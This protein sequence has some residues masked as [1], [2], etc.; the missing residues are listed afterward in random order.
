MRP[1]FL[2]LFKK[3]FERIA[4]DKIPK[5]KGREHCHLII[6]FFKKKNKQKY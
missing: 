1:R 6:F 4:Y 2:F 3:S 5:K